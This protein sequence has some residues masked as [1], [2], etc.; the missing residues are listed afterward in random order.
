[1]V[2]KELENC[3]F[4]VIMKDNHNFLQKKKK[5]KEDPLKEK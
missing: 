4:P 1:M 2:S 3:K 5:K